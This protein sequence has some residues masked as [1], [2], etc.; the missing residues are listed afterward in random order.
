ME[1]LLGLASIRAGTSG[2]TLTI[3]GGYGESIVISDVQTPGNTY[4]QAF[5]I[6]G[7]EIGTQYD[8]TPFTWECVEDEE[9]EC[10]K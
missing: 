2:I 3:G 1:I 4:G 8:T 9:E 6:S 7:M 10:T 5:A